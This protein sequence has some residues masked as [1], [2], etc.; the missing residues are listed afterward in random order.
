MSCLNLASRISPGQQLHS[1]RSYASSSLMQTM[2]IYRSLFRSSKPISRHFCFETAVSLAR[3]SIETVRWA[4]NRIESKVKL[5]TGKPTHAYQPRTKEIKEISKK[6]KMLLR[7]HQ[8]DRVVTLYIRGREGI[9]KTQLARE[10]GEKC[11]KSIMYRRKIVATMDTK[12][13]GRFFRSYHRLALELKCPL[14]S[15]LTLEVI[16]T[17]AQAKMKD[18]PWLLIVEAMTQERKLLCMVLSTYSSLLMHFK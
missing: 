15:N 11:Y 2:R 17:Q 1:F 5:L 14:Y 3:A 6:I 9:G 18:H 12:S 16:S 8:N 10:Y 7:Q 13:E 4:K